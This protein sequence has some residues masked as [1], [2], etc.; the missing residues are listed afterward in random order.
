[1]QAYAAMHTVPGHIWLG[2][3]V[4]DQH[5]YDER[6][7]VL[8]AV[9]ARVRFFSLEPL[10]GPI[11]VGWLPDWVIV[12][13][14]SGRG[15][16]LMDPDWARSLMRDCAGRAAF[17]MKQMAGKAEIPADLLVREFPVMASDVSVSSDDIYITRG[18][19]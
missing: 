6:A 18:N 4:E 15:F 2:T 19:T 1:M 8:R 11:A 17:F 7:P 14:E 9:D 13:G 10:L 16:R 5:R 12:G 3:S